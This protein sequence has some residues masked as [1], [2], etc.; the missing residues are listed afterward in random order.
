LLAL[1]PLFATQG[2][3]ALTRDRSAAKERSQR[4]QPKSAAKERS[5][6]AQLQSKTLSFYLLL[7]CPKRAKLPSYLT[8]G[9]LMLAFSPLVT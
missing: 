9:C 4:A 7:V 1:L 3:Q 5:Q 2:K 6:R 8:F